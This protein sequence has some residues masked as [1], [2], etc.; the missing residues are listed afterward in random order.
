MKLLQCMLMILAVMTASHA[1]ADGRSGPRS[2]DECSASAEFNLNSE[3]DDFLYD[4]Y[5][6][7]DDESNCGRRPSGDQ[8]FQLL[9]QEN[10]LYSISLD[11][12]GESGW[13]YLLSG[14][15]DGEQLFPRGLVGSY[16]EIE[17]AWLEQGTYYLTVEG[18]GE[19][20]LYINACNT[21]CGSIGLEDGLTFEGNSIIF[22]ETVD[23]NSS[24][25]NY[26]GPWITEGVPCQESSANE[27]GEWV[28]F[29]YYNWYNQDF[30]WS[31][32]FSTEGIECQ[33][34]TID[35]A[36]V[37]I[38][39]YENDYCGQG[40]PSRD[41]SRCQWDE[42]WIDSDDF[43]TGIL[44]PWVEPGN[45]LSLSETKFPVSLG[46]LEDGE[47]EVFVDIDAF[48]DQCAWAT[49]IWS[50]KLV[51][52]MSCR[53]IPPGPDGYDLGDLPNLN[54]E[55]Q[56]C[57][58]TNTPESGGPANAVFAS[59]QQIAWLGECV[60]HEQFPN[61]VDADICDDGVFFLPE[62]NPG[63]S[64][65]PG[66]T[67]C[68]EV[69]IT[70]GPSYLPGTPL[71]LW[72]W[73]D[74]NLD[75]DFDDEF[76]F[77]DFTAS[78][79]IIP[80]YLYY[81]EGPNTMFTTEVCFLDP[82]TLEFG[83]YDGHLRFR[84][85]SCGGETPTR[86]GD[87]LDCSS[88]QTYVD[89]ILGETEDYIIADL[90]L[91]VQLISFTAT[92]INGHMLLSWTTASEQDNDAYEVQ[93]WNGSGWLRAGDLVAGAGTSVSTHQYVFADR[94]V[95]EGLSYRY[96]LVTIDLNGNR[97]PVAEVSGHV[98]PVN[99]T[100]ET[101]TLHQNFPNPF[102]PTTEIAFELASATDVSLVIFDLL[103]RE[104]A[105]LV[106]GRQDAGKYTVSFDATGLPSG[107]Y[108]YR[109]Q[110]AEFTDMK[111]MMLLK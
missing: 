65:M 39:A 15:C 6:D 70:T 30:G 78:E 50:S 81:A 16:R 40:D 36:C 77:G 22:V 62:D 31:H 94:N 90:Q 74:G 61:T 32:F 27:D 69:A 20:Q 7:V 107:M 97:M 2:L 52:Y 46:D 38:C 76:S 10:G 87:L 13:L 68:V 63:G 51:V 98:E 12:D 84:L 33:D 35:S 83:R 67:V 26:N 60:T 42:V 66:E 80:G 34:F 75:C 91:P 110:T 54:E 111:K 105:S 55:E 29:G 88:A 57:Y 5:I 23:A 73:K 106:N 37:I 53:Q 41:A 96:R 3:T 58:P 71:Y 104:V 59:E 4:F 19:M 47:V 103:G 11:T 79:C 85:L 49:E 100:V 1:W 95:E 72:A 99:T 109:L 86:E 89:D 101:F 14:C 102:N 44:N 82:G 28:G 25:P 108:F 64:W 8:T 21:P 92:S 93:R 9:V 18:D 48:S 45:N 24:E 17:C 56:P 43:P